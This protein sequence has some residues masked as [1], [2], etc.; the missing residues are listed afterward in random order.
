VAVVAVAVLTGGWLLQQGVDRTE[1]L[2]VQVRLLQEVVDHVESSFVDEVDRNTLYNSAIEGIVEDLEDPHSSFLAASEYETLRIR[3]EGDYGGVGLEVTERNGWVTVVN[4]I[5]GTPGARAGLRSG[6]QFY[7]IEGMLADTMTTDH[8]VD[9]LRGAPGSPVE[10]KMLR[11]GVEEPIPFTLVRAVIRL[12]AVP[13]A[14]MLDDEIGYVP[15]RSVR[16]SSTSEIRVAVDSLREEGMVRLILDLRGNPG[17]LLDES[18]SISDLF[19]DAGLGIAETRGRDPRQSATYSASGPDR[20]PGMPVAVLVNGSSASA[21]EIIAGALQDHDRAVVVGEST[22]GKGSVQTPFLLSGGNVLKL[23]TAKWYTPLGRSIHKESG[24][25][26]DVGDNARLAVSG[27][28]TMAEDLESRPTYTSPGGRTIYGGGGIS[29]DVFVSPEVLSIE[30]ENSV[31]GIYQHAGQFTEAVFNFAVAYLGDHPDLEVGLSLG[32]ADLQA[33]YEGLPEWSADVGRDDF[34]GAEPFVRFHLER[35]IALQAWGE[36]GEF[37]QDLRIDL[38]LLRAQ[39][40]L[41]D[42]DSVDALM[43]TLATLASDGS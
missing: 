1:N 13:F 34:V 26:F 27:Q 12:R 42:V 3:T 16:E 25:L 4:P 17:G 19:L 14:M 15:F 35:E 43:A 24:E 23:T 20:Y 22:F 10:V 39:E 38:Q 29:P 31:R 18:I 36:A 5:P 28:I 33:F 21:S 41:R 8:A 30:Q 11:P 37:Q 32:R 2:Y 9:L 6:D 40:L 7:E